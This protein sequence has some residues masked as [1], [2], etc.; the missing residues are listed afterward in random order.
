MKQNKIIITLIIITFAF[1]SLFSSSIFAKD[2]DNSYKTSFKDVPST[3]P[4]KICII[5]LNNSQILSGYKDGTFKPND[6]VTVEEYIAILIKTLSNGKEQKWNKKLLEQIKLHKPDIHYYLTS[7]EGKNL[8]FKAEAGERWS[9]PFIA[10]AGAIGIYKYPDILL[11]IPNGSFNDNLKKK[12][13]ALLIFNTLNL[14]ENKR[15]IFSTDLKYLQDI[16]QIKQ[17]KGNITPNDYKGIILNLFETGVINA[18]NNKFEP[19][20]EISRAET[21]KLMCD[22]LDYINY[23]KGAYKNLSIR[24]SKA[25]AIMNRFSTKFFINTMTKPSGKLVID[26]KAVEKT[27]ETNIK[28]FKTYYG[29][30]RLYAFNSAADDIGTK[31]DKWGGFNN[32]KR[33]EI[34]FIKSIEQLG[35]KQSGVDFDY[36]FYLNG[37]HYGVIGFDISQFKDFKYF[38]FNIINKNDKGK[39]STIF[40]TLSPKGSESKQLKTDLVLYEKNINKNEGVKTVKVDLTKIENPFKREDAKYIYLVIKNRDNDIKETVIYNVHYSK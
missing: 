30:S 27:M 15:N 6:K 29:G 5:K 7:G 26:D 33:T 18:E 28:N 39:D 19:N 8:S 34:S 35:Y 37:N 13:A 17:E 25:F 2:I 10:T 24:N 32:L 11:D 38:N 21:A 16:N 9:I 31:S 40:V 12:D 3:H 14:I 4:D 22:L 20:K 1:A 23:N 36:A